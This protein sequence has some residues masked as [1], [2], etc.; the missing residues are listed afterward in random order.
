MREGTRKF[1]IAVFV[2]FLASF[3]VLIPLFGVEKVSAAEEGSWTTLAPLPE[4]SSNTIGAAVVAGKIYVIGWSTCEKY[5]P[6]TNNWTATA[7]LPINNNWG[8]VVAC[9]NKIYLIGGNAEYPTQ[10]YDTETDTWENKSSI[11]TTRGALQANV[12]NGKIY[13]IGGQKLA[14][15]YIVDA[16]ISNDVYDTETDTWSQMAPIPTAVMGYASVVFEDKIYIISG[17]NESGPDYNPTK[18]VQIFDPATNQW[19]NG[20][21]VPTGIISARACA[22]TGMFAPKRIYVIGGATTSYARWE[23]YNVINLTQIYDPETDTWTTG[24]PMLTPREDFGI[25]VVN[26]EIYAIGGVKEEKYLA[27]NEK[28]TPADFIPEFPSWTILPLVLT[29]T[30]VVAVCRKRLPKTRNKQS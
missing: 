21:S 22:T 3:V 17:G 18:L 26:D 5:D 25:A 15:L 4:S 30:A 2:P 7:P 11:P 24:A 23:T 27:V 14:G 16:S 19:T 12:V 8:A 28:Y 10:V 6:E 13:L 29:A 1:L 20:T 9:Q